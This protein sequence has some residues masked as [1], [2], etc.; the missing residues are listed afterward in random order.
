LQFSAEKVASPLVIPTRFGTITFN[1]S[2]EDI[3]YR[4][5]LL[6]LSVGLSS[7]CG[8]KSSEF[9][10]VRGQLVLDGEPLCVG[11]ISFRP[12]ANRGN[13]TLHH[14]TGS[15]NAQGQ[16]ELFT[17]GQSGAPP[18]WYKVLVFADANSLNPG[19]AHPLPPKWLTAAKYTRES[20]TD[21]IVEVVASS[22]SPRYDFQLTK[23]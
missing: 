23:R 11:T 20:T 2:S 1:L 19:Q 15:I 18:G 8:S 22:P 9:V 17:T 4:I 10:P 13:T 6:L 16:Y 14:P 3:M 5:G 12:L 7:G 21:L